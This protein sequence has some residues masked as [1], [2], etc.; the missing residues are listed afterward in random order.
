MNSLEIQQYL[1]NNQHKRICGHIKQSQLDS[2]SIEIPIKVFQKKRNFHRLF[3]LSLLI[4][5]GTTIISY[6]SQ[7]GKTQKIKAV[8]LIDTIT[9]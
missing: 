3:L 1:E 5:M 2:V 8:K 9:K 4:A 7:E 6:T